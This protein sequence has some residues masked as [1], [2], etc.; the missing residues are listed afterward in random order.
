MNV[1]ESIIPK[2]FCTKAL[3]GGKE[4]EFQCVS[5]PGRWLSY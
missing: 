2:G 4:E 1:Y 3:F 5:F